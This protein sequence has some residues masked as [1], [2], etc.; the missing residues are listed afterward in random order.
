[1]VVAYVF[2]YYFFSIWQDDKLAGHKVQTY[3][4]EE[5]ISYLVKRIS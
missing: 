4:A 3:R 5:R 2:L 1:M